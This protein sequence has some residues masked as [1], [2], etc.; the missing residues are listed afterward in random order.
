MKEI[1]LPYKFYQAN[2]IMLWKYWLDSKPKA[3]EVGSV[4]IIMIINQHKQQTKR[5]REMQRKNKLL[6][7]MQQRE[8]D[9]F[10]IL[11]N[12]NSGQRSYIGD[13]TSYR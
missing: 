4:V 10:F 3:G 8:Q 2:Y 1:T 6:L 5:P 9:L 13:Y 11:T 12:K 7:K